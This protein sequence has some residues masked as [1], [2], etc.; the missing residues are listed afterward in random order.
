MILHGK[1]YGGGW[2]ANIS[3]KWKYESAIHRFG[4]GSLEH[5]FNTTSF[6]KYENIKLLA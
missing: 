5:H 3:R 1:L 6:F 4:F 2:Y